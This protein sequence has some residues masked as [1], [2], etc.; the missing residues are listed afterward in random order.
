MKICPKCNTPSDDSAEFCRE[1]GARL[2]HNTS[3]FQTNGS[4]YH[5]TSSDQNMG[6]NTQYQQSFYNQSSYQQAGFSGGYNFGI[7]P[8]NIALCIL[9]SIITCGLYSIYWMI[10]IN[11]EVNQLSGEPNA[12]S[13]G[14]VFLFSL[15]TCGIY[16]LYWMYKMGERCERIKR[17]PAGYTGILYLILD[18]VGFGIISYALIQDT[19]NK[20]VA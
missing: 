10:K 7:A 16:G 20:A 18:L 19:L 1:C 12:T 6:Q 5:Q 11:D 2:P 14:M 9:F 8:R 3:D 13:G 17:V 4:D 15:I